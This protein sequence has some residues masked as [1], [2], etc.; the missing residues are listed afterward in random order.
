MKKAL[1]AASLVLIGVW[2]PGCD[3]CAP[4]GPSGAAVQFSGTVA[5]GGLTFHDV[6]VPADTD[7][8]DVTVQWT[9]AEASLRLIQIDPS[10]DPTQNSAC[11]R[12]SDPAGP[13]P[14]GSPTT[15]SR[16]LNH[17]GQA[18]TGRVRFMLEN[19]TAGVSASYS[20]N[21]TPKRH[22]CDR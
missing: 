7:S 2:S 16:S 20:G 17:Q 12:L 1:A 9:P 19:L 13:T 8:V 3:D 6:V 22:G 5:G 14:G 15:I 21:A 10:C 4:T 11:Q 18:A